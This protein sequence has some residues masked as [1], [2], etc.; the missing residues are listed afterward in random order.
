MLIPLLI[1]LGGEGWGGRCG[2]LRQEEGKE[3]RPR[4]KS[5]GMSSVLSSKEK[6]HLVRVKRREVGLFEMEN[7]GRVENGEG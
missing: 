5:C 4:N 6:C 3:I 1:Y 7:W 2:S